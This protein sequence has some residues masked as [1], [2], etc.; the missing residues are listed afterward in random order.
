MLV[1]DP[2]V[3]GAFALDGNPGTIWLTESDTDRATLRI[4]WKGQRVVSG[5]SVFGAGGDSLT[6]ATARIRSGGVTRL[7]DL[8]WTTRV[9]PFVASGHLRVAFTRPRTVGSSGRPMGI[10]ELKIE[11]LGPL[12]TTSISRRRPGRPAV[13]APRSA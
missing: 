9:E 1:G 4:R 7:V 2:A 3:A 13:S 11:G 8:S 10:G 12:A 6:L 5:L